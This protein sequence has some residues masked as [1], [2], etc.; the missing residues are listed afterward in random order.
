M[1]PLQTF[2]N[3]LG[4]GEC[5]KFAS[6]LSVKTF[7]LLYQALAIFPSRQGLFRLSRNKSTNLFQKCLLLSNG[8]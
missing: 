3:A 4:I 2:S 7:F 1:E 6:A 8:Y 5:L